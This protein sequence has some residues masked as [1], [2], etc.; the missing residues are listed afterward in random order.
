MI[1]AGVVLVFTILYAIAKAFNDKTTW[2][3]HR[4]RWQHRAAFDPEQSW[5]AKWRLNPDGYPIEAAEAPFWYF[6]LHR[7][8]FQE[9]FPYSSTWL[10]AFTDVWHAMELVRGVAVCIAL[11]ALLPG[12]CGIAAFAVVRFL[13]YPLVFHVCFHHILDR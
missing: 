12:W 2:H 7:P 1:G 8:A 11:I 9:R 6:G 10:V 13:I 3:W 5:K 4:F